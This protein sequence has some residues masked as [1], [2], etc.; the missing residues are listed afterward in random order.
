[1]GGHTGMKKLIF[2]E[3]KYLVTEKNV[4]VVKIYTDIEENHILFGT[5][6]RRID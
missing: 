2:G 1:M 4:I 5:T 6:L 3:E